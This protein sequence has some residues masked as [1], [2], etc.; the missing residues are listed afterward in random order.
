MD[1][2]IIVFILA[3]AVIAISLMIRSA[4][5]RADEAERKREEAITL[6]R[7]REVARRREARI[8]ADAERIT[9][10]AYNKVNT[11]NSMPIRS[12]TQ[13]QRV[14]RGSVGI[15]SRGNVVYN[16][17]GDDMLTAMILQ[18]ALNS[19]NEVTAGRVHWNDDVPTITPVPVADPEP[20]RT[21]YTSSYSSSS[22]SDDDSSSRSSYSSSYSSSSSDSSYSS[23]SD[24]SSSFS[25]D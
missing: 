18:N 4:N 6:L 8:Q 16:D 21:S 10:Q 19:Q 17:S 5:R 14:S 2:L 9:A 22:S 20:E 24:S 13:V 11:V 1:F 15:Q 7:Q 12:T 3:V 23:S 25:S